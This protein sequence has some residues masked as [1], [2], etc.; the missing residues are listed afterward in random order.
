[1]ETQE[2]INNAFY[3]D[4]KDKWYAAD[5]H[6][7]ALLRAENASRTPWVI[8]QIKNHFSFSSCKV[9]DIGCGAGFLANALAEQGHCVTGIDSSFESL[10][11]AKRKDGTKSA[12]YLEGDAYRLPFSQGEFDV[13]CAMDFLEHVEKPQSVIEQASRVLKPGG[14][15]FFHTFNRNPLSW[16][17][18]LKGVEW[19]VK[20]TPKNMH[21][22]RLFLKPAE[23]KTLC[24]QSSLEVVT[25][26][27]LV[28]DIQKKAF[29]QMLVTRRVSNAFSFRLTSSL[30]CGYMGIARKL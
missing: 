5:D 3:D 10:E 30:S 23:L 28:P 11:V 20:N 25:F 21:V 6:P 18:V 29:W 1:M 22:Y 12:T 9:L 2:E 7:I 24:A 17:V 27:G 15:F 8:D 14:L 19:F 26:Q 13:V 16:L 4:L